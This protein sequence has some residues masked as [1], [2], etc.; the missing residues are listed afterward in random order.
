[1]PTPTHAAVRLLQQQDKPWAF[2]LP[3]NLSQAEHKERCRPSVA[4]IWNVELEE[5]QLPKLK[6]HTINAFTHSSRDTWSLFQRA[7]IGT[8]PSFTGL[9]QFLCSASFPCLSLLMLQT[10]G[11]RGLLQVQ[12]SD[13]AHEEQKENTWTRFTIGQGNKKKKI[14]TGQR[15]RAIK[16][17][18]HQ[19]HA[20]KSWLTA[21]WSSLSLNHVIPYSYSLT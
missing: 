6:A 17:I 21:I 10:E 14:Q 8:S 9:Q 7:D 4:D 2:L 15:G 18:T 5:T 20:N 11:Q 1:M 13:C 16:T 19:I 3:R 12:C